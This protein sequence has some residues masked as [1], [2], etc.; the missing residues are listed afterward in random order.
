MTKYEVKSA[1][2]VRLSDETETSDWQ[3]TELSEVTRTDRKT[4]DSDAS[5]LHQITGRRTWVVEHPFV[6]TLS[7]A[8]HTG[9]HGIVL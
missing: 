1:I 3:E 6:D 8:S 2:H 5:I 7:K 4:A 9:S